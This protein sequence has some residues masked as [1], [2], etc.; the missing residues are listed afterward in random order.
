MEDCPPGARVPV[1]GG[2]AG[3]TFLA[4][5]RAAFPG[6]EPA[7]PSDSAVVT[8]QLGRRYQGKIFI[9][10]RCPFYLPAVVL[11]VPIEGEGGPVPP[12]LWLTCPRASSLVG[13]LESGGAMKR[14]EERLGSKPGAARAFLEDEQ[15]F[16][17]LQVEIALLAS[18][19]SLASR[20]GSRGVAG[21]REGAIKCLHAHLAYRLSLDA[22]E[23][24]GDARDR[25]VPGRWC[26][27]MLEE[28]GGVWCE[29][30]P[31]ACVI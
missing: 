17:A 21:G 11:T 18:G 29:R 9:T 28:E 14:I 19:E 22:G 30:P 25:S 4:T 2:A 1:S 27:E 15:R 26:M 20:I 10:R 6:L 12:L 16:A 8:S 23:D 24:A 31:A 7:T 5:A 3:R 13:T